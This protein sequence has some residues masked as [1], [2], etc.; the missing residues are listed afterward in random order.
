M[1][2]KKINNFKQGSWTFTSLSQLLVFLFA[3]YTVTGNYVIMSREK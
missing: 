1:K 2:K 3:S